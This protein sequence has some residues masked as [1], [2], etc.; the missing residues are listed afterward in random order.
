MNLIKLIAADLLFLVITNNKPVTK[1]F[2]MSPISGKLR[3]GSP[4]KPS[5][6]AIIDMTRAKRDFFQSKENASFSFNS[7][8]TSCT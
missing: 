2:G 7:L 5:V 6:S 8:C 3:I 4:I 1:A